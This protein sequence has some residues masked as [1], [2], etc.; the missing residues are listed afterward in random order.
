MH[1][2]KYDVII[3]SGMMTQS[4][5]KFW[6]KTLI[7]IRNISFI[8]CKVLQILLCFFLFDVDKTFR[9]IPAKSER[10]MFR[11]EREIEVSVYKDRIVI[12]RKNDVIEKSGAVSSKKKCL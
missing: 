7:I 5:S 4:T 11:N 6:L 3:R 9:I 12:V 8:F 1:N 10:L 2:Y